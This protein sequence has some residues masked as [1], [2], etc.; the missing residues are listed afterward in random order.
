MNNAKPQTD[1]LHPSSISH[2]SHPPTT[3]PQN[4]S[5]SPDFSLFS[6][7]LSSLPPAIALAK[8]RRD[9]RLLSLP[10]EDQ[11]TLITWLREGL[12]FQETMLRAAQPRPEG[13]HLKTNIPALHRFYHKHNLAERIADAADLVHT[14]SPDTA[15]NPEGA[16]K[17][18]AQTH[19]LH[20]MAG[21][22]LDHAAFQH[23]TRFLLR[24]EDQRIRQRAL[25]LKQKRLAFDMQWKHY[26]IFKRTVEKLPEINEIVRNKSLSVD[27]RFRE[28]FIKTFGLEAVE[29][30]ERANQKWAT[31][32]PDQG[33]TTPDYSAEDLTSPLTP[34][35]KQAAIN[36]ALD[37]MLGPDV[38]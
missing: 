29:M 31:E 37:D 2:N 6:D 10:I 12:T 4:P 26:D 25:D 8:A 32:H 11:E 7:N 9:D 28:H 15:K 36:E 19:A 24:Q 16:F 3:H 18:L 5:I 20:T 1:S 21:P 34:E 38:G 27:E 23:I 35:E 14:I 13:L 22:E 17:T 33:H 30:I